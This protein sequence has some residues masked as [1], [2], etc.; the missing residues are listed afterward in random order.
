MNRFAFSVVVILSVVS[1][2]HADY[3]IWAKSRTGQWYNAGANANYANA[4]RLANSLANAGH[5]VVVRDR[6]QGSPA[7]TPA[8]NVQTRPVAPAPTVRQPAPQRTAPAPA[9]GAATA[10]AFVGNWWIMDSMGANL[11]DTFGFQRY[12]LTITRV[13]GNRVYYRVDNGAETSG[14]YDARSGTITIAPKGMSIEVKAATRNNRRVLIGAA[15][16]NTPRKL[17]REGGAWTGAAD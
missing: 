16:T 9:T 6:S 11:R 7:A 10:S 1:V 14:T 3:V 4:Q 8:P 17:L 12:R 2:S 13:Q 5:T 15:A